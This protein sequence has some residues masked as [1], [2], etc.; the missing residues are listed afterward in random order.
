MCY[1]RYCHKTPVSHH[2]RRKP[3]VSLI[4]FYTID[5]TY[6]IYSLLLRLIKDFLIQSFVLMCNDCCTYGITCDINSCSCHIK[7]TVNT[8][9][10]T[11]CL[12]R[13][14]DRVKYHCQCNQTNT[15][16]SGCSNR[17][18]CCCSDNGNII[19][20]AQMDSECL[21]CEYN[22]NTLHDGSTIHVDRCSKRNRKGRNLLGNSDFLRKC[23]N[24]KRDCRI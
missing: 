16:Y 13:K 21:S 14:S 6:T 10:Q 5:S 22:R 2:S 9:D 20:H 23:F 7:D 17:C 3:G 1:I 12:N 24:R 8:H 18:Q 4:S 19:Y 11:D 15:W